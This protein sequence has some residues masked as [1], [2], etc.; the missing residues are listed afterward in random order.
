MNG[1]LL[2]ISHFVLDNYGAEFLLRLTKVE[3]PPRLELWRHCVARRPFTEE[4]QTIPH[5]V[6]KQ[7]EFFT[8]KAVVKDQQVPDSAKDA[9]SALLFTFHQALYD[10]LNAMLLD[11]LLQGRQWLE[12]PWSLGFRARKSVG[13]DH[14]KQC[15]EKAVNRVSNVSDYG[16]CPLMESPRGRDF[17]D[18]Q[19]TLIFVEEIRQIPLESEFERGRLL[20]E[21]TNLLLKTLFL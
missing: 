8:I 5:Q 16:I 21:L 2:E 1:W 12:L 13:P 3:Q 15:L 17:E 9:Y 11:E 19:N 7:F 14:S 20:N 10:C 6:F 4:Y 18:A